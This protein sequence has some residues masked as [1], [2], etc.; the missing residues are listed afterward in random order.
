MLSPGSTLE[1]P[2]ISTLET[3]L[4]FLGMLT[5]TFASIFFIFLRIIDLQVG[6]ALG[7]GGQYS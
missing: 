4:E 2:L 7:Q 6:F 5:D 3:D 1:E